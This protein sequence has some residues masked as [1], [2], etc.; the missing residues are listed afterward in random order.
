MFGEIYEQSIPKPYQ[1]FGTRWI[2]HKVHAME[3]V[4]NNYG[5]YMKHLESLALTDSHALKRT[6]IEGESKKWKNAKFPIHL[7]IYLDVL[8]PIKVLSLGFKKEKHDPV[9]AVRR[10]SEFNWSMSKLQL[11]IDA[12]LDDDDCPQLTHYTKLLKMSL[13]LKTKITYSHSLGELGFNREVN[14]P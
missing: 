1:S 4:L 14:I 5:I 2:A 8:T 7:A 3:I 13:T 9:T 10:V 12:S 6:E 11:L